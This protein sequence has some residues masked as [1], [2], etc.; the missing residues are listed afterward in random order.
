MVNASLENIGESSK[1]LDEMYE[2]KNIIL[3]I[4]RKVLDKTKE[5]LENTN[6]EKKSELALAKV[7]EGIFE[8]VKKFLKIFWEY[9]N[10]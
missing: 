9:R 2:Y 1:S 5:E 7:N 4:P 10:I 6:M 3:P 8:K